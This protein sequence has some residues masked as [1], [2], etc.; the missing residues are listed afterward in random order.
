MDNT[1]NLGQPV[2]KVTATYNGEK[3]QVDVYADRSVILPD[4]TVRKVKQEVVDALIAKNQAMNPA[5][6]AQ[7]PA[8]TIVRMAP[9]KPRTPQP[10]PI[11]E[12]VQQPT[13]PVQ[14]SFQ[15]QPSYQQ[16]QMQ[17]PVQPQ[18]SFTQP[19]T[20]VPSMQYQNAPIQ[21][22]YDVQ[23]NTSANMPAQ[24][25]PT[26]AAQAPAAEQDVP[27]KKRVFRKGKDKKNPPAD[28]K[29]GKTAPAEM[30]GVGPN[31]NVP[32]KKPK[33][34]SKAGIIVAVVLAAVIGGGAL[35]Y[36]YVPAFYDG[37]NSV[38][39]AVTGKQ[40][41]VP[42]PI[43]STTGNV[44]TPAVS[45][46]QQNTTNSA[47]SI[48]GIDMSGDVTIE[49]YATIRTADGREYKVP[50]SSANLTDGNLQSLLDGS[51][52]TMTTGQ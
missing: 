44:N 41:G 19:N 48:N 4:G 3:V 30:Q 45:Q 12:Q 26:P 10:E 8:P 6:T 50:L 52:F 51:G 27:D 42:A 40:V 21:Q 39:T 25:V 13:A 23:E 47:N 5:P 14:E 2:G 17:V 20:P 37:V 33:K 46:P 7:N 1:Q 11:Q 32:A 38:L 49:F 43:P 28:K 31:G 15:P 34:K 35:G 9:V 18:Q 16:P 24:N 29:H 36:A 22:N